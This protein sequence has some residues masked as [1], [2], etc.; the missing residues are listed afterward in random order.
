MRYI[1]TIV[2][3]LAQNTYEDYSYGGTFNSLYR[4]KTG[5]ITIRMEF[6]VDY[7]FEIDKLKLLTVNQ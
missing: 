1:I 5:S 3:G 7:F 6:V 4:N 2:I